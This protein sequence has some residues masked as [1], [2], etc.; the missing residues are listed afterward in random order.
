MGLQRD[1]NTIVDELELNYCKLHDNTFSAPPVSDT[2]R[3][4]G[5][6]IIIIIM[7]KTEAGLSGLCIREI[8]VK[9]QILVT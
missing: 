8:D 9:S 3:T 2:G 5:R 1:Y 6:T 4:H 7:E